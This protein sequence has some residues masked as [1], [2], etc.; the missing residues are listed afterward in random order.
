MWKFIAGVSKAPDSHSKV[1]LLSECESD[2]VTLL[3]Y[4]KIKLSEQICLPNVRVLR[5]V[6][7][8]SVSLFLTTCK[9][10][11]S[12]IWASTKFLWRVTD[13]SEVFALLGKRYKKLTLHTTLVSFLITLLI[14]S[15]Q[16]ETPW[17]CQGISPAPTTYYV[18]TADHIKIGNCWVTQIIFS[19]TI[20]GAN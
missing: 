4:N 7:W 12:W 5:R 17:P 19:R 10:M 8:K 11:L 9:L 3:H 2:S 6:F 14:W 16:S 18:V 1:Q 20:L 15:L 13:F